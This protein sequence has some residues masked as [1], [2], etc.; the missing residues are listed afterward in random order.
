MSVPSSPRAV[1]WHAW[2]GDSGPSSGVES[3]E[4]VSEEGSSPRLFQLPAAVSPTVA[5]P[6]SSRAP[7]VAAT[8]CLSWSAVVCLIIG[9]E[10]GDVYRRVVQGGSWDPELDAELRMPQPWER[11]YLRTGEGTGEEVFLV[12]R[13]T[14]Q[15]FWVVALANGDLVEC[16]LRHAHRIRT[17]PDPTVVYRA[18]AVLTPDR[19]NDLDA[20]AQAKIANGSLR[21]WEGAQPGISTSLRRYFSCLGAA[22]ACAGRFTRWCLRDRWRLGGLFGI[23]FL[24]YELLE[25]GGFFNFISVRTARALEV[26]ASLRDTWTESSE[27]FGAWYEMFNSA[28]VSLSALIE[29]W[30]IGA[31]AMAAYLL[32]Q[33]YQHLQEE[34]PSPSS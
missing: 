17:N 13:G 33:F 18:A 30:K 5:S 10:I 15:Y 34:G 22:P 20:L 31:Y 29:P 12:R 6:R 11:R 7:R 23:V 14:A 8:R 25:V 21:R 27:T 19:R 16:D 4:V 24:V 32:W 3:W 28:Y 2:L 9:A 1:D 26:W